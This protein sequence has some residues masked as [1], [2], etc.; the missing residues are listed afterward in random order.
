MQNTQVPVERCPFTL[1]QFT[2]VIY[3]FLTR[4]SFTAGW[5]DHSSCL[6]RIASLYA[7]L[8]GGNF[9]CRCCLSSYIF[10]SC[11]RILGSFLRFC[12]SY[13]HWGIGHRCTCHFHNCNFYYH[14]SFNNCRYRYMP[15]IWL[16][17]FFEFLIPE[18]IIL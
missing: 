5:D 15:F 3:K 2:F 1:V 12:D 6:D 7:F 17:A 14:S 9:Q 11:R 18:T 4:N 10:S 8:F 13:L 16:C